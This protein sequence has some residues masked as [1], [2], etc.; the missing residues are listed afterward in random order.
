MIFIK[1]G[2]KQGLRH[3]FGIGG[4]GTVGAQPRP[5]NPPTPKIS[6][7]GFRPVYFGN[8]EKRMAQSGSA[9]PQPVFFLTALVGD[10]IGRTLIVATNNIFLAI[11]G[12]AY[13]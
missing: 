5:K 8:I 9:G 11:R 13:R 12:T 4:T 6:L 3:V 1:N 7:L 10:D 2:T